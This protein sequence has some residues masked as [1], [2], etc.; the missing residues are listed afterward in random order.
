MSNIILAAESFGLTDGVMLGEGPAARR[1]RIRESAAMRKAVLDA[2]S[3]LEAAWGGDRRATMLVNEAITTS[4]LF[5]SAA[6]EVLDRELMA[7]YE[8]QPT[9]WQKIAKR[10]TL[11]NFKPKKLVDLVGATNSL[12]RV[13]EHTNYPAAGYDTAEKEISVGK[14]GERFGYTFEARINDEIGEL[15]AVPG[16]WAN[17][18]RYTEDD[19]ALEQ[20]A[21]PLTGAPNTSFFNAGNG[22]LGTGV[23]TADRLQ[24]AIGAVSTKRDASGRIQRPGPLQLVVGPALQFTAERV[25]NTSEIEYDDGS[26]VKVRVPNPFRGKVTLTVMENLPG[27]AWFVLPMPNA[28]RPA[29]FVGFLAGYESPDVRYKADQGKAQGGG[30][31]GV[32]A[33][34]F[35]DDTI[36]YRVRHITGAAQ[37]DPRFTYASDG[38]GA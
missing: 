24:T 35:D 37:G 25:M 29:F 16:Q 10:T 38:V 11:R 9:Q 8:A 2:K 4:D 7:A 34:S 19:T 3:L 22:N 30:D 17:K 21:N 18:A 28:P 23:L 36:S 31:L 1:Q 32:D 20:L 12:A 27:T 13:P 26:G 33:G 5:K 6:G 14:F 15:Q